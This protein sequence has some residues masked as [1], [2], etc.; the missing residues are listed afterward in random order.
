MEKE[1]M[2]KEKTKDSKEKDVL[3]KLQEFCK[4]NNLKLTVYEETV[5]EHYYSLFKIVLKRC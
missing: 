2:K 4:E 3:E 5:D 1:T